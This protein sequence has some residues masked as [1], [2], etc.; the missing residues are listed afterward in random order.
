MDPKHAN[1]ID[2]IERLESLLNQ[3]AHTH[4]GNN[5][6]FAYRL[7]GIIGD[8]GNVITGVRCELSAYEAR[9]AQPPPPASDD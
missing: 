6:D 7:S 1:L 3:I 8:V 2:T 5:K 9:H 4:R